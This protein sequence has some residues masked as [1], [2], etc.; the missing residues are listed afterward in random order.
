LTGDAVGER[1][2]WDKE[3]YDRG[4]VK[5]GEGTGWAEQCAAHRASRCPRG[6]AR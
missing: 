4:G 3:Q 2:R 1:L 5:S 6:G